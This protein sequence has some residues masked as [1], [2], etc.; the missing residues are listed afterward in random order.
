M[1]ESVF[2]DVNIYL[3]KD[4]DGKFSKVQIANSLINNAMSRMEFYRTRCVEMEE[5]Y[6]LDF[7]QFREGSLNDSH[8][9]NDFT[10]W[11][12]YSRAFEEWKNKCEA[13]RSFI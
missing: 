6:G 13:L 8:H 10:L 5:K 11:Q 3:P 2:M 7:K 12:G 1:E 9:H 4:L